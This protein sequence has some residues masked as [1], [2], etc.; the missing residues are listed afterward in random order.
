[1]RLNIKAFAAACSVVWGVAMFLLSWCLYLWGS[2]KKEIPLLS[3][4]YRGFDAT[5][6]G[7][8]FGILWGLADGLLGGA[9]L[10]WLYNRLADKTKQKVEI[11]M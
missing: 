5:P 11:M 9:S 1:M 4:I 7:S 8:L 10:A 2:K 6:I 3:Q